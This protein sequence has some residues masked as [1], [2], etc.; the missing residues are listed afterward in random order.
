MVSVGLCRMV[1]MM[2]GGWLRAYCILTTGKNGPV[3]GS[4][5]LLYCPSVVAD[6]HI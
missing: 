4:R 1:G 2:T 3:S 6:G 5:L